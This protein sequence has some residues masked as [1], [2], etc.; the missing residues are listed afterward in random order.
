VCT[1]C[2]RC[3]HVCCYLLK[4]SPLWNLFWWSIRRQALQGTQIQTEIYM[5]NR[6]KLRS[7]GVPKYLFF[8]LFLIDV[9]RGALKRS[10]CKNK[11]I[12][13]HEIWTWQ[14]QQT[15]IHINKFLGEHAWC[16][17]AKH[18]LT[19]SEV[20][21]SARQPDQWGIYGSFCLTSNWFYLTNSRAWLACKLK[22]LA[23]VPFPHMHGWR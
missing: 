6:T 9:C 15:G 23:A 11:I 17:E 8:S 16:I 18:E 10:S 2:C 1:P 3:W 5:M 22:V 7:K 21:R 19:Q 13:K 12:I 14:L 4:W 20:T